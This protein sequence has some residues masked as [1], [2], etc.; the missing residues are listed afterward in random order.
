M[1]HVQHQIFELV[2][3]GDFL[4]GRGRGR[5]SLTHAPS[6]RTA[7]AVLPGLSAGRVQEAPSDSKAARTP[8]KRRRFASGTFLFPFE[9]PGSRRIDDHRDQLLAAASERD[10]REERKVTEVILFWGR[11]STH[12]HSD[13][14]AAKLFQQTNKR[15]RRSRRQPVPYVHVS[16]MLQECTAG[17]LLDSS[18]LPSP[19]STQSA[20]WLS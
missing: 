8:L 4:R 10:A 20:A 3:A 14:Q 18:G 16:R 9:A 17:M 2:A 15:G 5:A 1:T 12:A 11:K 6:V 13:V 19:S 7:T